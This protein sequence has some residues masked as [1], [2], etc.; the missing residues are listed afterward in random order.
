M[1]QALCGKCGRDLQ[2][3]NS[4][5]TKFLQCPR[6]GTSFIIKSLPTLEI[7]RASK[8][9]EALEPANGDERSLQYAQAPQEIDSPYPHSYPMVVSGE[10]DSGEP[11]GRRRPR[12]VMAV[13]AFGGAVL[14]I[15]AVLG[16]AALASLRGDGKKGRTPDQVA[17]AAPSVPVQMPLS[18]LSREDVSDSVAPAEPTEVAQVGD[19]KR[20]PPS[21]PRSRP[22]LPEVADGESEAPA[23]RLPRAAAE[24]APARPAPRKVVRR[25]DE[26]DPEPAKPARPAVSP[27]APVRRPQK[28]EPV[29]DAPATPVVRN[30]SKPA[31]AEPADAAEPAE[32]ASGPAS[33][34]LPPAGGAVMLNDG[35]TLVVAI[36]GQATLVY[37][38]TVANKELKRVEVEVE[39]APASL[40]VQGNQ[41]IAS[42]KGSSTVHVLAAADGKL[43]RTIKVTG[44]PI[45]ALAC[46][47]SKGLIYATNTAD[48]VIAINPATGTSNKTAARGQ[49]LAVGAADRKFVYTGIQKPIRDTLVFQDQGNQVR[50]TS[51]R[52]GING[53]LLQFEVQG[54]DLRP[55]TM[56][57]NAADNGRFIAVSADGK[58][59]AMAG[60]GGW[61]S[62]NDPKRNYCI[63]IFDTSDMKT[64]VGQIE[65]EPFPAAIAFHPTLSLGAAF[66]TTV[67]SVFST[68]SFTKKDT[69]KIQQPGPALFLGFGANGTKVIY[70]PEGG[71]NCI[72][73]IFPITLSDKDK[74]ALKTADSR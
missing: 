33:F 18:P 52:S 38:D 6:C 15:A 16:I 66:N 60:G 70:C 21:S 44:E 23:P 73:Q 53:G 7:R 9:G 58:L 57:D 13:L 24:P 28:A 40:V 54:D 69:F 14:T 25:E 72:T 49:M 17:A 1:I 22:S 3:L 68:K 10:V 8:D 74:A 11:I 61:K 20:P 55:I 45:K 41:L 27:P 36:T 39:F 67:V 62:K 63:A 2:A 64:M 34:R 37:I 35:K 5:K 50:V 47:P 65:T 48:E 59:A 56:N 30:T 29:D 43:I 51:R 26:D 46:N 42:T 32:T 19:V 71:T 12:P 31:E 4:A